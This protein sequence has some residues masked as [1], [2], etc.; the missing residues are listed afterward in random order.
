MSGIS[1]LKVSGF[2]GFGSEQTLHLAVPNG[3]PGSGLTL[4]VGPNNSGKSTLVEAIMAV[5]QY[6]GTAPTFSEGKRN[7]DA[8]SRVSISLTDMQGSIRTVATV[9]S[10]GSEIVFTG[11]MTDPSWDRIFVV[12]SRRTFQPEFGRDNQ[13]RSTYIQRSQQLQPT[14]TGQSQFSGRMFQVNSSVEKRQSFDEMIGRVLKS[15]PSWTIDMREGGNHYLKYTNGTHSHSS[16][17]LGEGI[18]N[19]F[20]IIDAIYDSNPGDLIVIDEPE[21][22]LHPQLQA[23]VR[24]LIVDYSKDRQFLVSTHSPKFISWSSISNGG[25]I[26]RVI[27][28]KIHHLADT[29]RTKIIGL[30]TDLNNPHVLGLD[31]SEAFFLIDGVLLLEGQEDVLFFPTV[32]TSLGKEISASIFGWGVGGADKMF[33]NL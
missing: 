31:A 24:D 20:F 28:S 22:S 1:S 7:T 30:L 13:E 5:S 26:A 6:E 27:N 19:I 10:G 25:V 32:L 12:P 14:R 3:Q 23:K 33:F 15:V 9:P 2:R 17:G 4:V 21:L 16:D 8:G 11:A 29:T 18:L